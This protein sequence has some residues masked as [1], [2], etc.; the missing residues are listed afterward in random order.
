[1]NF[2]TSCGSIVHLIESM[3]SLKKPLN[4]PD[5]VDGRIANVMSVVSM[6]LG[7]TAVCAH[8]KI[9]VHVL[10]Q[11]LYKGWNQPSPWFSSVSE[12]GHYFLS[13]L[14]NSKM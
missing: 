9:K 10:N 5:N 12:N 7:C 3:G 8:S 11:S 14:S 6:N 4:Q 1:M 2:K 13:R